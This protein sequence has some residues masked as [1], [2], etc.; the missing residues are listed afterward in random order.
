VIGASPVSLVR[1]LTPVTPLLALV[2][3][4]LVVRLSARATGPGPARAALTAGLTLALAAEPAANT[5]AHDRIAART[6]TRVLATAWMAAH[7]PPGAV[8][9]VLGST[10]FPI[11]DP[12]LPPGV[13]RA[14]LPLA[15][16]D[17]DRWRTTHVVT[18]EHQL[19]FSKL[20]AGQMRVLGPRLRLLAEFSPYRAGPAGTFEWW[21]AFYIPIAG[22]DGVTRPGPLVRIYALAPAPAGAR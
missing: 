7:L 1:Y 4:H 5:I 11:S 16:T 22:F 12:E 21:D 2:V 6:D 14:P 15:S 9:A 13:E 20:H 18:H 8:A 10:Y 3:A 17:L 19:R